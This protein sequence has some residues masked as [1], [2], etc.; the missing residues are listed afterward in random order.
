M[1]NFYY[2]SLPID[3]KYILS[4]LQHFL[5]LYILVITCLLIINLYPYNFPL[6]NLF[7]L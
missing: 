4:S 2:H 3:G 5:P 7:S 6:E 1:W